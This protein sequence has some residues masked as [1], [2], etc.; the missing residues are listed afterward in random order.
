MKVLL[1]I[2][3]DKAPE[4]MKTLK[5]LKFLKA[6]RLTPAKALLLKEIKEAVNELNLIKKGKKKARNAET[7][8]NEL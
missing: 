6:T 5:G 4:F 1:D 2:R 8:L 7:F 3:D